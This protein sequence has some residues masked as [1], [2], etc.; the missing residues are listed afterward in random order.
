M[1][2]SP[3]EAGDELISRAISSFVVQYWK[4]WRRFI[5]ISI[6]LDNL[7]I[8]ELSVV[9]R[10]P[11]F[12]NACYTTIFLSGVKILFTA[13]ILPVYVKPQL[14]SISNSRLWYVLS[15]LLFLPPSV[16]LSFLFSLRPSLVPFLLPSLFHFLPPFLPP[17][18]LH[19]LP[20]CLPNRNFLSP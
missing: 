6:G 10:F 5:A 17:I 19:F 20:P 3:E 16:P 13:S 14:R 9:K 7:I 1:G 12:I 18:L 15:N 11:F 8:E 2:K 4:T